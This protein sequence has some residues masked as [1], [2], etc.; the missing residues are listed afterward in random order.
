MSHWSIWLNAAKDEPG[1][2]EAA[3]AKSI[4]IAPLGVSAIKKIK[5]R[6][7]TARTARQAQQDAA[8]EKADAEQKKAEEA[9]VVV[10]KAE[11]AETAAKKA[12][13]D[14]SVQ[15]TDAVDV[16]AEQQR[17]AAQKG[18]AEAAKLVEAAKEVE[19]KQREK[20]A[21]ALELAQHVQSPSQ[22]SRDDARTPLPR[23]PMVE[24]DED[25]GGDEQVKKHLAHNKILC[26]DST[27]AAVM[28]ANRPVE[29]K[30]ND[31][32]M[33]VG[34]P[35][36]IITDPPWGIFEH[37]H[38]EKLSIGIVG[39]LK[40]LLAYIE[41]GGTILLML[42]WP[43]Y[44]ECISAKDDFPSVYFEKVPL[45]VEYKPEKVRPANATTHGMTSSKLVTPHT[46]LQLS[47]VIVTS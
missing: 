23:T 3:L 9:A 25:Q 31:A 4:V 26:L 2:K 34:K 30:L 27:N 7:I 44:C 12:A 19:R 32:I 24:E 22:P 43:Q 39:V 8:K 47:S 15:M 40:I 37:Y 45:V 14:L 17:E 46:Q 18:A 29:D 38:D 11:A 16:E 35:M 36:L 10:Q 28:Q 1:D 42:S 6:I 33:C 13:D 20:A 5:E 21:A 41:D